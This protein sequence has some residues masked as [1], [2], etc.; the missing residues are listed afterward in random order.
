MYGGRWVQNGRQ[1]QL[2]WTEQ[3]IRDFYLNNV[4][5]HELGHLLDQRNTNYTD[6]E[7]YAEWFAIEHGY[8]A[9]R[10]S[11]LARRAARKITRRHGS[12]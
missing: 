7:R 8:R 10:R 6:R 1:W 2:I 3:T 5:M 12:R 11:D 9:S 4:L